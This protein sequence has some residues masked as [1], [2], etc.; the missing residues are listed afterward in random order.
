M[1]SPI[2]LSDC[3]A[4]AAVS[5]VFLQNVVNVST[6]SLCREERG[7]SGKK[8]A[9]V[10]TDNRNVPFFIADGRFGFPSPRLFHSPSHRHFLCSMSS[11]RDLFL[12]RSLSRH[13]P[14]SLHRM[15]LGS[16][17]RTIFQARSGGAARH[18]SL[19]SGL[20]RLWFLGVSLSG[21]YSLNWAWNLF[22]TH[23]PIAI[24]NL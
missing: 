6:R 24:A 16:K 23:L 1:V 20:G 18:I 5:N 14:C 7:E 13:F 2:P 19:R 12:R 10:S 11:P 9:K 4:L 21:C 17:T 8:S 15:F 22:P 3:L